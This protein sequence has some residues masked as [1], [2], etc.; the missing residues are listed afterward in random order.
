MLIISK[1]PEICSLIREELPSP[2][3]MTELLKICEAPT[4]LEDISLSE[5]ELVPSVY[6]VAPLVRNRLTLMRVLRCVDF[7]KG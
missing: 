4:V 6:E 7:D 1:L 3:E 5:K 2:E